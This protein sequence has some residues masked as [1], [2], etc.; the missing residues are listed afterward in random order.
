MIY[1]ATCTVSYLATVQPF[2]GP[3]AGGTE[4]TIF[5]R[6][7]THSVVTA[8]HFGQYTSSDITS[9]FVVFPSLFMICR[10]KQQK[11][12]NDKYLSQIREAHKQ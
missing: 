11:S 10:L 12:A 7:L 2:Y 8:V 5:G 4:V 9:R 1:C 3:V 6:N